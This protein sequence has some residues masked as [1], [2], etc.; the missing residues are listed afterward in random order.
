MFKKKTYCDRN[1]VISQFKFC[2]VIVPSLQ[3]KIQL[4]G[5]SFFKDV[6]YDY[7]FHKLSQCTLIRYNRAYPGK[8][9][10]LKL[11]SDKFMIITAVIKTK[12]Y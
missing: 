5:L 7:L 9:I 4:F 8:S 12:L 11:V 2:L 1:M 3:M 10:V 6:L